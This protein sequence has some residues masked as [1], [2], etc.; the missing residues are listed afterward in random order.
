[1]TNFED[2]NNNK[3]NTDK[4]S[5]TNPNDNAELN[6]SLTPNRNHNI[7]NETRI[8]YIK[9]VV[10]GATSKQKIDIEKIKNELSYITKECDK[11]QTEML[12]KKAIYHIFS[13]LIDYKGEP[14]A[15]V[16]SRKAI[17]EKF[18]INEIPLG[19]ILSS[20][21]VKKSIASRIQYIIECAMDGK[22]ADELIKEQGETQEAES[23]D[24]GIDPSFQANNDEK[25]LNEM[26]IA[27]FQFSAM[28]KV[29]NMEYLTH[30]Y[31]TFFISDTDVN[32]ILQD[33]V[34]DSCLHEYK[35]YNF[36]LREHGED[37]LNEILK[38]MK[39]LCVETDVVLAVDRIKNALEEA[40]SEPR[41][42]ANSM[43]Y[44]IDEI[45]QG[46]I[47][48]DK[49]IQESL[50]VIVGELI[51]QE[52]PIDAIFNLN[53]LSIAYNLSEGEKLNILNSY[54]VQESI[55]H[56]VVLAIEDLKTNIDV[57]LANLDNLSS[58]CDHISYLD[59]IIIEY[60]NKDII[61]E[62]IRRTC[63]QEYNYYRLDDDDNFY[64]SDICTS[65]QRHFGVSTSEIDKQIANK[66][67][68]DSFKE[69]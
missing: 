52:R 28:H 34:Q 14:S 38:L 42:L 33:I 21:D 2:K 18:G 25:M 61:R 16:N 57:S 59:K 13:K 11:E 69:E 37:A 65:I 64:T 39:E 62:N 6:R 56:I 29:P 66:N 68:W 4:K 53:G 40:P 60:P 43:I 26:F 12:T 47:Y 44:E 3:I 32:G 35:Y 31:D 8:E 7:S 24:L 50:S 19:E 5:S 54:H 9:N 41:K 36:V 30:L 51:Y 10:S 67:I 55:S 45:T 48:C 27:L 63:L 20:S 49:I 46:K 15:I 17:C 23:Y 22:T 1:M 58:I